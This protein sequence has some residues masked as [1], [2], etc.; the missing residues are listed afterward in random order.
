MIDKDL[1]ML[2]SLHGPRLVV[3]FRPGLVKS[4]DF[5]I[6][7]F[8]EGVHVLNKRLAWENLGKLMLSGF[9]TATLDDR[10]NWLKASPLNKGGRQDE[11][12]A[13]AMSATRARYENRPSLEY[14]GIH[15]LR[16]GII[17]HRAISSLVDKLIRNGQAF[18]APMAGL[19][20]LFFPW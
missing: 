13:Y 10:Q 9:D 17:D 4:N 14:S 16:N 12:E 2:P 15:I 7:I 6:V 8:H 5:A 11:E 3:N 18:T 19:P 20:F 1:R